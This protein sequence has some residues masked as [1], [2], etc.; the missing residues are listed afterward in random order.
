VQVTAG[1]VATAAS[2]WRDKPAKAY[3]PPMRRFW[4]ALLSLTMLWSG[5][6]SPV[7]AGMPCSMAMA[8]M[9]DGAKMAG[10]SSESA[11]APADGPVLPDCCLD[12]ETAARTGQTCK[13]GAAC[14]VSLPCLPAADAAPASAQTASLT[15]VVASD[16]PPRASPPGDVWRPPTRRS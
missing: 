3:H 4:A 1:G 5:V 15:L 16:T 7:L 13:P 11:A 9:T 10:M 8:D 6:V 2:L 12:P 14:A